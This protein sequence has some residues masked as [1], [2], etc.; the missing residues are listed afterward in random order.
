M[1]V[2]FGTVVSILT[3]SVFWNQALVL[4]YLI[5]LMYIE[6]SSSAIFLHKLQV[7][8][9]KETKNVVFIK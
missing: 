1:Y 9:E 8:I 7:V 3:L 4:V 6:N 2:A 5:I